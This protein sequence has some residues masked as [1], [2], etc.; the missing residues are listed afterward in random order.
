MIAADLTVTLDRNAV[1]D[2]S[3]TLYKA[4]K[5]LIALS[6]KNRKEIQLIWHLKNQNWLKIFPRLDLQ[7]RKNLSAHHCGC[8]IAMCCIIPQP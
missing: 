3:I 8:S 6:K 5:T 4:I 7:R 1:V 2:F